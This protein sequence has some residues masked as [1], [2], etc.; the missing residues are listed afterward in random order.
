M[1]VIF[2]DRAKMERLM[3]NDPCLFV[4]TANVKVKSWKAFLMHAFT[5]LRIN[6]FLLCKY[7]SWVSLRNM[8]SKSCK[9]GHF[10]VK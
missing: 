2:L 6:N 1:M 10:Q 8:L 4:K 7:I 3:D 5:H 9:I